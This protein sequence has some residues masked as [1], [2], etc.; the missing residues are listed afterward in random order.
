VFR[1]EGSGL[2]CNI[3]P[4]MV[5]SEVGYCFGVTHAPHDTRQENNLLY[6]HQKPLEHSARELIDRFWFLTGKSAAKNVSFKSKH[7]VDPF[8]N[9]RLPHHFKI[10]HT[11]PRSMPRCRNSAALVFRYWEKASTW[12]GSAAAAPARS[13]VRGQ[14]LSADA[15][16]WSQFPET[17]AR[18]LVSR[19][20]NA[21]TT[22]PQGC[23]GEGAAHRD[24]HCHRAV[25]SSQSHS[26]CFPGAAEQ[27]FCSAALP[28]LR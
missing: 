19:Q 15:P 13:W 25:P 1:V 5:C 7:M 8:F 17:L 16:L 26:T 12:L 22:A 10:H 20:T 27:H 3:Q 2:V 24:Q 4:L 9:R 18:S 11:T 23:A 28:Y 21:S 14:P 6:L